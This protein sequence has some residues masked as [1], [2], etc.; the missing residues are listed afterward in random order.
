MPD[1]DTISKKQ[2]RSEKLGAQ[3]CGRQAK[4]LGS[5]ANADRKDSFCLVLWLFSSWSKRNL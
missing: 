1:Q 4:L 2:Y 5:G 3:Q